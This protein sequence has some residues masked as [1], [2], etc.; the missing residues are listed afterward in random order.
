MSRAFAAASPGVQS[1]PRDQSGLRG[2]SLHP[3]GST[4]TGQRSGA[5]IRDG[6]GRA[7]PASTRS[8][9]AFQKAVKTLNGVSDLVLTVQGST[10]SE[11]L[12]LFAPSSRFKPASRSVTPGS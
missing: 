7:G 8:R 12:Q 4:D 11:P 5:P 3:S 10:S 1:K 9:A 2:C 6:A